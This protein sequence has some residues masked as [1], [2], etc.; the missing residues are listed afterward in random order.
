MCNKHLLLSIFQFVITA[1]L[2]YNHQIPPPPP[3]GI[4]KG[5]NFMIC[6]YCYLF[7]SFIFLQLYNG[8]IIKSRAFFFFL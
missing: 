3:L 7:L 4:A 1:R 6:G 8:N 2:K 5:K